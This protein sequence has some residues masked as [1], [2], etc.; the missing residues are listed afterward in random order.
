MCW[1]N[2]NKWEQGQVYKRWQTG[3]CFPSIVSGWYENARPN[4][5]DT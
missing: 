4:M 3:V 1:M 2:Q 5:K